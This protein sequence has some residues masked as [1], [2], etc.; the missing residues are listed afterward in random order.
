MSK[1]VI[2]SVCS[3]CNSSCPIQVEINNNICTS[4]QANSHYPD[5]KGALCTRGISGLSLLTDK[6]R[7]QFPMLRQGPRGHGKW[8]RISWDEAIDLSARKINQ[9][10]SQNGGK[11]ILWSDCG[12]PHT[13]L[14]HAFCRALGS[15]NYTTADSN[16]AANTH[17]A[18]LS[19]FGFNRDHLIYDYQRANAIILQAYNPFESIDIKE[20]N[21]L[22]DS[23]ESGTK[24]TVIDIRASI[25]ASKA[26]RFLI[27]RPGTDYILNLT[28]IALLLS[29]KLYNTKFVNTWIK[30]EELNNL[31]NFVAPYNTQLAQLETGI[32]AKDIEE[33]VKE[34][35]QAAP[36]VIWHP[37]YNS[38]R[39]NDSFYLARSAYIINILLGSIGTKGGLPLSIDPHYLKRQ[40]LQ[41]FLNSC[42]M[43]KEKRADGINSTLS[44]LARGP[45]LLHMSFETMQTKKPYPLKGYILYQ[46]DPLRSYPEPN[47][48]IKAFQNLDF[49]LCITSTWTQTSWQADIILPLST[50]LERDSIISQ[51]NNLKPTFF[52]RKRCVEPI[53]NTKSDWEIFCKL[54]IHIGIKQL[55]FNN[56]QDIWKWQL[57]GTNLHLNDFKKSG[58]I[59]LVEKPVFRPIKNYQFPN[60]SKKIEIFNHKWEKQGV[61]SLAPYTYKQPIPKGYFR[62]TLGSCAI[63]VDSY[64]QNNQLLNEIMPENELWINYDIGHRMG[65]TNGSEVKIISNG[66]EERIKAHLNKFIHPEAVFMIRGFG[67][68]LAIE[69]RAFNQGVAEIKLMPNG[70]KKLDKATSGSLAFQEYLVQIKRSYSSVK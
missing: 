70:L 64:T 59:E 28:V 52:L 45:G 17:H 65:I 26:N 9:I 25:T 63:H 49:I 21:K 6:E 53:F 54:A 34:L 38:S 10:C 12:G 42:P 3:I 16:Y 32:K 48:L 18:A 8:K 39:Y 14:R 43:P 60:D 31:K 7:P 56:I 40:G 46:Y 62:L 30:Q 47:K 5:I 58:F 41:Y 51:K 33:L 20:I 24:L 61:A 23:I 68:N 13:D 67:H 29:K 35:A 36:A 15:P 66:Y 1:K 4:I 44:H 27:I 37:G 2:Y 22:L 50:Y 57:R 69:T 19:L 11:S 55:A